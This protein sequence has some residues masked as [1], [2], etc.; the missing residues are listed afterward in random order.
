MKRLAWFLWALLLLPLQAEETRLVRVESHPLGTLLVVDPSFDFTIPHRQVYSLPSDWSVLDGFKGQ[1]IR[2]QAEFDGPQLRLDRLKAPAKAAPA[3]AWRGQLSLEDRPQGLYSPLL[4]RHF[5]KFGPAG[6]YRL[7]VW[8]E[9]AGDAVRV[10]ELPPP[11]TFNTPFML[12][13]SEGLLDECLLEL[14]LANP[15]G[16]EM[17]Q[18]SLKLNRLGATLLGG[19]PR[20][21]AELEG[22]VGGV[23]WVQMVAVVPS[24]LEF[25]GSK[26]KLTPDLAGVRL[27]VLVPYR[28]SLPREWTALIN[29]YL[30]GILG[31]GLELPVPEIYAQE[32][33]QSGLLSSRD[34]D[35]F[36]LHLVDRGDRRANELL[37]YIDDP[38][39]PFWRLEPLKPPHELG[40][41][42]SAGVFQRLMTE[43]LKNIL[44]F[45]APIPKEAQPKKQVF[46]FTVRVKEVTLKSLELAYRQGLLEFSEAKFDLHWD[47]GITSGVE[48][49]ASV[50][51]TLKPVVV[52]QT[53]LRWRVEPEISRLEF[54]S[55][56]F[57]KMSAREKEKIMADLR[58]AMQTTPLE[59]PLAPRVPVPALSFRAGLE[60]TDMIPQ[61]EFLHFRGRLITDG[62]R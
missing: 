23:P 4:D 13:L 48:P 15:Q 51:G 10:G 41:S 17:A 55:D 1:T 40:V 33:V 3:G 32:L 45:T 60:L 21:I 39:A 57:R 46:I 7:T 27:E 9:G 49:G 19:E 6:V 8:P 12:Q 61:P 36:R 50:W 47:A 56:R 28:W 43:Q 25:N 35:N 26:L 31:R 58:L 53:P 18:G 11:V 30:Q 59:V 54:L 62:V 38:Q 42:L 44:P 52:A 14:L 24:R 2:L 20:L 37:V 22:K 34:L 29:D 5:P 16:F